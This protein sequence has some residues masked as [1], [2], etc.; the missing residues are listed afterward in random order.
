MRLL[1]ELPWGQFQEMDED[2]LA[3]VLKGRMTIYDPVPVP[4]DESLR[5][6]IAE[7]SGTTGANIDYDYGWTSGLTDCLTALSTDVQ[8][9]LFGE[10][11]IQQID[12]DEKVKK[13]LAERMAGQN[14]GPEEIFQV[15]MGHLYEIDLCFN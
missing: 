1:S 5:Q 8:I 11:A 7:Q 2:D 6:C 14:W 4:V 13:Y 10:R 15:I 3:K 12:Y 9:A